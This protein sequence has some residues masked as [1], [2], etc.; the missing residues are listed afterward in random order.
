MTQNEFDITLVDA[1]AMPIEPLA[2]ADFDLARNADFASEAD[3]RYAEFMA[4][5]EGIMVWQRIRAADVFAAG[6]RDMEYSLSLQLG[7]LTKSLD[8]L[9]D[10]P[11]YLE[12][13]YGIGMIGSA[14]GGE[15]QWSEG[16]APAMKPIYQTLDDVPDDLAPIY[17]NDSPIMQ[18][19]LKMIEY[20]LEHS[21]G[22]LPMSWCDIQNPL[23]SIA[24]IISTSAVMLGFITEPEKI[25][26]I[27]SVLTDTLIAFTQHQTEIIG[28]SLARPGHGFA[29]SR[30]GTGIGMSS[31]NIVMI[32]PKLFTDFCIEDSAKIGESFGG[33]GIHSCGNWARWIEVVKKIPN[34]SIMDAAFSN[35]I[36]PTPNECEP[37]RDSLANSGIILHARAGRNPEETLQRAKQ[38]WK[39]GVKLIMTTRIEDPVAQHQLYHD[40]H[41]LCR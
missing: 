17:F 35:Q 40:L 12:P 2:P 19:G 1:Q 25:K 15:Y 18:D 41:N 7:G 5:D 22:Q 6:S 4:K 3:Q 16:Q 30:N 33:T 38:L 10:A 21:K 9:T 36:D 32:A 20:F 28:D 23:N 34:I 26:R 27:L 29:S 11:T 8:Y 13:W 14:F 39:P 31:D 37:W 24:E